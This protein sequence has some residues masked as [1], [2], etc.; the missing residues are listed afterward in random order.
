MGGRGEK[1]TGGR[2]G[3]GRGRR[4]KGRKEEAGIWRKKREGE[5]G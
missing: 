2:E 3:R 1:R 4:T 5:D